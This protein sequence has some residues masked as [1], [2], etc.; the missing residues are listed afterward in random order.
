VKHLHA[1]AL[2]AALALAACDGAPAGAG[3]V[4]A[5]DVA[6]AGASRAELDASAARGPNHF[7]QT[8]YRFRSQEDAAFPADPAVCAAAPFATNVPL[9]ASL[10]S[11]A[12]S[13]ADARVVNPSVRRVGSATAC[14]RI[15]DF[16]FTPGS[17]A[18]MYVKFDLPEGSVTALGACTVTSNDVPRSGLVLAGCQFRVQDAPSWYAGGAV[19]SLS[20]FNPARLA[21]FSTGSEWTVQLFP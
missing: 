3:Q 11:E 9:G 10:W 16:G 14:I 13:A 6:L 15:T 8:V 7:G 17:V 4:R 12:A 5:E 21:G 2:A 18:P 19:T 1:A 20:I